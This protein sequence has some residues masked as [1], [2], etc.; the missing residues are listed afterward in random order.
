MR[1]RGWKGAKAEGSLRL[2]EGEL[3]ALG[4]RPQLRPAW[5]NEAS[6]WKKTGFPHATDLFVRCGLP[7]DVGFLEIS[8]G[9]ARPAALPQFEPA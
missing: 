3:P 2:D 1:L 9:Q 6:G 8:I 5:E 4:L 7:G